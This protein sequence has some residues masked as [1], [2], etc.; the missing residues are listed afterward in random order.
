MV[1]AVPFNGDEAAEWIFRKHAQRRTFEALLADARQD[2]RLG[3]FRGADFLAAYR[4]VYATKSGRP[5]ITGWP[6]QPEYKK[7]AEEESPPKS[8]PVK[9]F[10]SF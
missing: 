5:P 9:S 6:L 4:S 10:Y 1:D 3:T 7:R 2:L 8:S